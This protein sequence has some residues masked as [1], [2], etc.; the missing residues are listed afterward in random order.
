MV[1]S[2]KKAFLPFSLQVI[3]LFLLIISSYASARPTIKVSTFNA[4]FATVIKAVVR[5]AYNRIGYDINV[6]HLPG[7]RALKLSNIG[8]V[9]AEL[10]RIAAINKIYPNL[11]RIPVPIF[12]FE[13]RAFS[14]KTNFEPDGWNSLEPY[15]LAA[16]TGV[17][18]TE[19][20]TEGMN[21]E[22]VNDLHHMFTLLDSERVDL[23]ITTRV[24]GN[25]TMREMK[26]DNIKMLDPPVF[27]FPVFH[28][29]HKSQQQLIPMLTESLTQMQ[30][31]GLIKKIINDQLHVIYSN[32]K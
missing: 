32:I 17:K 31:E 4:P 5:E 25:I 30:N 19:K 18:I 15:R 10:Y 23:A 14:K 7:E 27:T 6:L 12:N 8:A 1:M 26:L 13:V 28:F 20:N 11:S 9:E 21:R 3:A 2:M 24:A 16:L 29:V 22:L